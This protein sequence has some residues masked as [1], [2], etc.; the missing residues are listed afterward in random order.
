MG[1]NEDKGKTKERTKDASDISKAMKDIS[2]KDKGI[3]KVGNE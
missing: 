2:N 3:Y 1:S